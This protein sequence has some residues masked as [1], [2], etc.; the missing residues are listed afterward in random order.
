M[1]G[2]DILI[3]RSN[4]LEISCI[5]AATETGVEFVDSWCQDEMVVQDSGVI[6][7]RADADLIIA[8]SVAGVVA[9]YQLVSSE[10]PS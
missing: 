2:Y 8:A 5:E 6:L 10:R 1:N 4:E 7:I 3:T 9:H